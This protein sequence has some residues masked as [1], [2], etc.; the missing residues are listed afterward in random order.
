MRK[1][2][3]GE[4]R[5]N[6]SRGARF[7]WLIFVVRR[8]WGGSEQTELHSFAVPRC[9]SAVEVFTGGSAD[10]GGGGGV[11]GMYCVR[12]VIS[13]TFLGVCRAADDALG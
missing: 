5:V 13:S 8:S 4:Q 10:R 6:A 1:G 2:R 3:P 9:N 7:N 12:D 11:R